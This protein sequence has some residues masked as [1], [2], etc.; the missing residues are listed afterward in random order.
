MKENRVVDIDGYV[1]VVNGKV[2]CF[3]PDV[4]NMK[5]ADEMDEFY[6]F[7]DD[8]FVHDLLQPIYGN[9]TMC[10]LSRNGDVSGK[11]VSMES[12]CCLPDDVKEKVRRVLDETGSWTGNSI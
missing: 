3:E 2:I 8:L 9:N 11:I 12:M 10:I 6:R 5:N 4:L 1:H 7:V